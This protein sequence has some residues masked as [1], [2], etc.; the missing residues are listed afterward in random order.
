MGWYPLA[1]VWVL[2]KNDRRLIYP[3]MDYDRVCPFGDRRYW[4]AFVAIGL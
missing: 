2:M 4:F 3:L 1:G